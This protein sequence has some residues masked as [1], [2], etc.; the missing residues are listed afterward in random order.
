MN[1]IVIVGGVAGGAS[2]AARLRRLDE[3][4]RIILFERGEYIS[5]ANCG[6]PY[7]IGGEITN[8]AALTLQ[9]PESFT[10]RFNVDVRVQ[11]EVTAIDRQTKSVTV[12]N[13]KT[14]EKYSES[15]DAL[16]LSPGA[17]PIWPDIPGINSSRV[18]KL[19]NIPDTY[20]IKDFIDNNHPKSAVVVGG[21]YI[22]VEMAENL[23][24]AKLAVTIIELADQVIAPLDY[25][26]AC[27]VHRYIEQKGVKLLLGN[28]VQKLE[29]DNNG[30]AVTFTGGSIRADMVIMAIGVRPESG[31]AKDAGLA[32]N[33]RGGIIVNEHMKTSDDNIYAVGDAVEVTDFVSGQKAMIPLAGPA[34]KQG[35][36]AADNICGIA[37]KYEGTQGSAILKI[38]DMTVAATG[39]NEKTAKRLGIDYDKSF[40]WSGSHAGYYPG[41]VNMSIKTLFEKKSGK[42]LG[43][44][45][46]GY[47]GVDKRC[48]VFAVA[49]RAGMTAF[50]LAKL[51]LCYAP[52]YSSAKDPVNMAGFVIE[53]QLTGKV[54]NFHWHDVEA[55][56]RDGTITLLD[57]R[58]ALEFENGHIDGFINIPLEELRRR[59]NE[60]DKNKKVY[61]ICQIGL[62]GYV[63][64]RILSQNGFDVYNL[65]G[66]F[67]LYN[68]IFGKKAA[69]NTASSAKDAQ[70]FTG[71]KGE[72]KMGIIKIDACGLQCPGPIVKLGAAV[73]EAQNG[74]T[75]EIRATDPAFAE[76]IEGYCR[77]TGHTFLGMTSEKGVSIVQIRK[78]EKQAENL[79][80]GNGK[81]FI[82]FS[83]DLDK[84]IASFIMANASAALGRKVS[85][86]FTFWGLNILRKP[87][88]VK[89]KKDFLSKM[90]CMMMPRGSK[91]LGLSKMNMGGMG[92]KMIRMVMKNKN[93]DSLE[94]LISMAQQSGVDLI[95]CSMS[96]DVMGIKAEELIDGVKLGGAAAMLAHAEESD[97]S[98]FI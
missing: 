52:P 11:N 7:Y 88:K 24:N 37:S 27:D 12:T 79:S 92:P 90:F 75:I 62:R 66:G 41:A 21:G 46:T 5:F 48:D 25:D 67:R 91:K 34:N 22:G 51:E 60:L 61:I 40:T 69:P 23:K 65:N 54:K 81:N 47:D 50:D 74:E 59:I 57:V 97:M 4:A 6:L 38:F 1:K 28:A 53:N 64:A 31:I 85:M 26:M 89:V 32:I 76:D 70:Q 83:G 8:K 2:A 44:Q 93:V 87:K 39:I 63:A 35:R 15:Y 16:I 71:T 98:L 84:A 3:K 56:P 86:F 96:M 82:V 29:E 49:V 80:T 43:A 94:D 10:A 33:E 18:F 17:E 13:L 19:R 68:S 95:A 20:K 45:I 42:I 14:G 9:T 73:K 58:I 78:G 72:H 55:L 36:I 30:I 77:R